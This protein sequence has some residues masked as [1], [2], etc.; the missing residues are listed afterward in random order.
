[1]QPRDT[2]EQ[3]TAEETNE[4]RS[5]MLHRLQIQSTRLY[6]YS[7]SLSNKP[8]ASAPVPSVPRAPA[9]GQGSCLH[10][11]LAGLLPAHEERLGLFWRLVSYCATLTNETE[12]ENHVASQVRR[13]LKAHGYIDGILRASDVSALPR[14]VA[15]HITQ[16]R[17][18]AWPGSSVAPHV[19][20]SQP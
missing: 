1:M 7:P 2:Q 14:L 15:H 20:E 8:G 5:R 10:A 12:C 11:R 16:L 3:T 4:T 9:H 19:R 17:C 13:M 6:D 18:R